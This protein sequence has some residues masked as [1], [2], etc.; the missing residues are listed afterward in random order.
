MHEVHTTWDDLDMTMTSVSALNG[1]M[2]HIKSIFADTSM[3]WKTV[4]AQCYCG[5]PSSR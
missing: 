5:V 4:L 1:M 3:L 2:Q